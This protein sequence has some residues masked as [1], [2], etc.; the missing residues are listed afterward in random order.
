M[1]TRMTVSVK[2]YEVTGDNP[3]EWKKIKTV[4][5]ARPKPG[6]TMDARIGNGM[7]AD[8]IV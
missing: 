8:V 3:N 1:K 7:R 4:S 2:V 6:E 5:I